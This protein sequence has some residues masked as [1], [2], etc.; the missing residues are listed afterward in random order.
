MTGSQ[1]EMESGISGEKHWVPAHR[2]IKTYDQFYG[3]TDEFF[4][5][6]RE[7][8]SQLQ[9]QT[10][11]TNSEAYFRRI[12]ATKQGG[13]IRNAT[14]RI[15]DPGIVLNTVLAYQ[16]LTPN[17]DTDFEF[18]AESVMSQKYVMGVLNSSF[19]DALMDNLLNRVGQTTVG[20]RL[21]PIIVPT[22]EQEQQVV[23]IVEEAIQLQED[24]VE[25]LDKADSD[26]MDS[27]IERLDSVVQQ[28]Y[29]LEPV[30]DGH[31][32]G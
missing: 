27:I 3:P 19:I 32:H 21:L 7:K 13:G 16:P 31:S 15:F 5:W 25:Q 26:K 17:D 30:E 18:D 2:S 9:E 8:V 22:E 10:S 1:Q 4:N 6:S 12:L 23:E 28:I 29:D 11:L 24:R 14:W 20:T